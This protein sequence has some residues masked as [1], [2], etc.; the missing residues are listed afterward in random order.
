IWSKAS[1]VRSVAEASPSATL[2]PTLFCS[3]SRRPYWSRHARMAACT[4]A[5]SVT[6]AWNAA[7]SP[8][9]SWMA[10]AVSSAASR[11]RSITSTRAPS[12]ASTM[13]VARPLPIV[14][15]GVWPPPKTAATF[16]STLPATAGPLHP[17]AC[18]VLR[19]WSGGRRHALPRLLHRNVRPDLAL[20][21]PV[22]VLGVAR[23]VEDHGGARPLVVGRPRGDQRVVGTT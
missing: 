2:A 20:L 14:S 7:A 11:D 17:P 19:R 9:A 10:A 1:T 23:Q 3:R 6:S 4:C 13:A 12:R 22:V 16:P 21:A 18:T 15:P 8:P 5:S